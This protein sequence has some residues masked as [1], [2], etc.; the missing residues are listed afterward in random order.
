[1]NIQVRNEAKVREHLA[2]IASSAQILE[3]NAERF[4]DVL[5][6]I[7]Q[8]WQDEKV[9]SDSFQQE[10]KAQ[11]SKVRDISNGLNNFYRYI[12]ELIDSLDSIGSAVIE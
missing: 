2:T 8:N 9:A 5:N 11:I 12:N 6:Q 10:A 7:K 3:Q 4:Q 1:M